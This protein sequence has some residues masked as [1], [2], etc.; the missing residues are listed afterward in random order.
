[1]PSIIIEGPPIKELDSKR[2]L[3]KDMTSAAAKAYGL[4]EEVMIVLIKENT[5]DNV[6]VG[7]QLLCDR[8]TGSPI[9]QR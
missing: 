5:S 9:S 2:E 3:V 6:G 1:M 8:Q 4:P 7:G